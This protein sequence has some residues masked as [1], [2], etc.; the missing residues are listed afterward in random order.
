[1]RLSRIEEL[2]GI[3]ENEVVTIA[4]SNGERLVAYAIG[5]PEGSRAIC[6]NGAAAHKIRAA[7]RDAEQCLTATRGSFRTPARGSHSEVW[8]AAPPPN[9]G[10]QAQPTIGRYHGT[11][12]R[13]F[14]ETLA[15]AVLEGSIHNGLKGRKNFAVKGSQRSNW[16]ILRIV[17]S[18]VS[19]FLRFVVKKNAAKTK[20]CCLWLVTET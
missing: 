18:D 11:T 2:S 1:M 20:G 5:A 13:R 7:N 3:E 19:Q 12:S 4:P 17:F 9:R 10:S 16:C 15:S 8:Q 14:N 6:A